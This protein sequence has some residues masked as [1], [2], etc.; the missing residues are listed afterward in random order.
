MI[1]ISLKNL[2]IVLLNKLCNASVGIGQVLR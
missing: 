2:D 1:I